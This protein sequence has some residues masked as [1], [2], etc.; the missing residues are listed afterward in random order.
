MV[1]LCSIKWLQSRRQKQYSNEAYAFIAWTIINF[2]Q[3]T[4]FC[5][6]ASKSISGLY[7]V[8]LLTL[9]E[10][11]LIFLSFG[12]SFVK[13]GFAIWYWDVKICITAAE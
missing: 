12:H 6:L 5:I 1:K 4:Q 13:T 7:L 8:L 9:N 2:E 10:F 3:H 11:S